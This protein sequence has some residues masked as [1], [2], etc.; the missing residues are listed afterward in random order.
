[1]L[2]LPTRLNAE[3][4]GRGGY[5]LNELNVSGIWFTSYHLGSQLSE[6]YRTC[7]K[8]RYTTLHQLSVGGSDLD[9]WAPRLI[10][11]KLA[12]YASDFCDATERRLTKKECR[13]G[14][15]IFWRGEALF[16]HMASVPFLSRANC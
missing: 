4:R 16:A 15:G 6:S 14:Q 5:C 2:K 12:Q 13:L 9:E 10:K 3:S 8:H 7:K 1:M 11:H